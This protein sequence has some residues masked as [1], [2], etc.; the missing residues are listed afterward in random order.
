[1]VIGASESGAASIYYHDDQAFP[2]AHG[3][4]VRG[5]GRTTRATVY[6]ASG[7]GPLLL[8][9]HSGLIDNRFTIACGGWTRTLELRREAPERIE[10]P[11]PGRLVTLELSAEQQFV[12]QEVAP[13]SADLR[14]LGVWIEVLK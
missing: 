9:V 5:G 8:T 14:P 3:F 2:E 4:W 1:M 7:D 11:C 10:V 12:P 13:P 6:R